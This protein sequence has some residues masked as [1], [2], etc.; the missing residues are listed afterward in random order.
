MPQTFVKIARLVI[1]AQADKTKKLN[2]I[3][4]IFSQKQDNH[5]VSHVLIQILR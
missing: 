3:V 2:A 5:L 1:I 4:Y